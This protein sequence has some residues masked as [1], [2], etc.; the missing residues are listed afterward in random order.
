[1]RGPISLQ[2]LLGHFEA[3]KE[4]GGYDYCEIIDTREAEPFFTA[5]DLPTLAT[6]GR[7]LFSQRNMAPRAVV[8][9]KNDLMTFGLS[10]LFSTLAAP[11]VTLRAFDDM[12]AAVSYIQA[13][14][15]AME[16]LQHK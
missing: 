5:K 9:D 2:D 7:R 16:R 13:M 8:A 10:R 15:A 14:Q 11:W 4:M 1:M 12:P 3:V 6:R